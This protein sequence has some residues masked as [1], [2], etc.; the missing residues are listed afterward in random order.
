MARRRLLRED[1]DNFLD[2]GRDDRRKVLLFT[3]MPAIPEVASALRLPAEE[4][5]LR[6]VRLRTRD[7]VALTYI[8]THLRLA[9]APFVHRRDL[10]RKPFMQLLEEAGLSISGADQT[11]TSVAAPPPVAQALGVAEGRPILK[12]V[13]VQLWGINVRTWLMA[14]L[15]ACAQ[16]GGQSPANIDAFVPWRMDAQRLETMRQGARVRA[17]C[18]FNDSS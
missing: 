13:T 5:V 14:Y 12:L 4:D 16:A 11:I 1:M 9:L 7:G 15:Q 17:R 8:D 3:R 18:K 10:E 6:V 2:R